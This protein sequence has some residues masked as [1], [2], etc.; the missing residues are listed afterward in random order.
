[1][2]ADRLITV[3]VT[4][5]GMRNQYGEFVPGQT[6]A[7]RTWA[8]VFDRSLE[9]IEGEGGTRSERR[10]DWRVRWDSRFIVDDLTRVD[11]TDGADAYNVLQMNEDTGRFGEVRR[12]WLVIQ[13]V[14]TT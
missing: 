11:I 14:Y 7:I 2:P 3:N 13:G 12:R 9:D 10:R 4:G 6:V 8:T 1:M 5:E